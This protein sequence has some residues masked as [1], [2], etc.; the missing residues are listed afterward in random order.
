MAANKIDEQ[1]GADENCDYG[2][3]REKTRLVYKIALLL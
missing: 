1:Q 2:N 3:R